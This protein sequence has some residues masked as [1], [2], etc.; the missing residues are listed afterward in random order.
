[1]VADKIDKSPWSWILICI[2][3]I[4][5]AFCIFLDQESNVILLLIKYRRL[6]IPNQDDVTVAKALEIHVVIEDMNHNERR[7]GT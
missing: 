5:A 6:I 2:S 7:T 4:D 1:M 3:S